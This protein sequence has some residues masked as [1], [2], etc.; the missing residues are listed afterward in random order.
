M[1]ENHDD[2]PNPIEIL[3]LERRNSYLSE[4]L[5]VDNY[6]C[7]PGMNGDQLMVDSSEDGREWWECTL[8]E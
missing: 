2:E 6:N 8:D 3:K 1:Q 7:E 5:L 4:P